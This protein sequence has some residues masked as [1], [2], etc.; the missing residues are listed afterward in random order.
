MATLIGMSFLN[1]EIRLIKQAV[2]QYDIVL[3]VL[4]AG[5]GE[6]CVISA[7][8]FVYIPDPSNNISLIVQNMI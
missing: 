6:T 3:D 7:E 1:E 4:T 8:C 5:Q 2:R